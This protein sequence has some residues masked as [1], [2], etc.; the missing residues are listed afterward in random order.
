MN[1]NELLLRDKIIDGL[2]LTRDRLL[3]QKQKEDG[4]LAISINGQVATIKARRFQLIH[5]APTFIL[6]D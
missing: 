4:N 6:Q 2:N 5:I 3:E 1:R